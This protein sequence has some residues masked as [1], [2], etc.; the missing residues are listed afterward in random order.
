MT[1]TLYGAPLSPF[2]RK[3]RICLHEKALD[4]PL[5]VIMPF[6]TPDWYRTEIS[7]LGRIPGY[8]DDQVALADSSVICQYLEERHPD[9]LRLYGNNAQEAAKVRWFEKYA[10]YE[11]APLTTFCI[12]ANRLLSAIRGKTCDEA[13]ISQALNQLLPPHFDYLEQQLGTQSYLLG[14]SF[15]MADIAL[16]TQLI[17]MEYAGEVLDANRWPGL[18]ALHA[19]TKTR[20]SFR[21][22]LESEQPAL[23]SL[24]AAARRT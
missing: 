11:L 10:D 1:A 23:E 14:S 4:Y 8:R 6:A 17:N 20:A 2:V 7:P 9:R 12:F 18:D 5:E 16:S 19:R 13:A 24:Y 22:V 15:S 3:A 21:A